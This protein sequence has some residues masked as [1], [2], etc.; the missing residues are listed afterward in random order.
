MTSYILAND[1]L[2]DLLIHTARRWPD[3]IA[4]VDELKHL[5]FATFLNQVDRL[6]ARIATHIAA[7]D[8]VAVLLPRGVDYVVSMFAIWKVGGVYVP[9]DEQWPIARIEQILD[10]ANIAC[11]LSKTNV[12]LRSSNSF[13]GIPFLDVPLL[14]SEA[15]N[16]PEENI[17]SI[18]TE[19]AYIIHTSGTSGRAKG[20]M[21]KHASL[22]NLVANHQRHLYGPEEVYEGPVAMNASFCFDSSLER[23][24]LIALGYTLHIIADEIRKSP[25]LLVKYIQ[26]HRIRNI[27]LVPSHLSVLINADLLFST[28]SLQLVIVGGEAISKQLWITL[29]HS[30]KTFFNVYGPTENTINTTF[31][32]ITTNVD[33][34]VIGHALDGVILHV[35]DENRKPV[36][37]E[38]IGELY[39]G[40]AQLALGY[41]NQA[42]LTAHSF[43]HIPPLSNERLYRTGDLVKKDT[44]G[45]L[46]FVGRVDEQV[47]IRGYRIEIDDVK[48]TLSQLSGVIHAAISP[49]RLSEQTALLAT[50]VV[51]PEIELDTLRACLTKHLPVYMVPDH[52]Q[53][54][55]ELPLTDNLKLDH[56]RLT[57]H[58]LDQLESFNK[59]SRPE[60]RSDSTIESLVLR[61]WQSVLKKRNIEPNDHFFAIGGDSLSAMVLMVEIKNS[62]G[63]ELEIA[64]IFKHPTVTSL[65]AH[66]K[67]QSSLE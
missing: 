32:K 26:T 57:Q 55:N 7:G 30:D 3:R 37:A 4:V 1:S 12:V 59:E 52:W 31:C 63:I 15:K 58:Y 16:E 33:Q 51:V 50:V 67:T 24:S 9:L 62:L 22:I 38:V 17:T 44:Q 40:G 6:A 27:D 10:D 43:V 46:I 47:K 42:T 41:L 53:S 48:S 64:S 28:P 56:K 18:Q 21:I 45:R 49:L 61:L 13:L 66:I 8:Y 54:V 5:T 19:L 35:L 34:P 36:V 65:A 20:V 2:M 14:L 39:V 23:L 11:I 25:S 60:D 29:A